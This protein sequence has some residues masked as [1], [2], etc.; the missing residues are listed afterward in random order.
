MYKIAIISGS[1]RNGR[2]THKAVT[3]LA[4]VFGQN[5]QAAKVDVLDVL[6]YNF[7]I[8]TAPFSA[9]NDYPKGAKE[10]SDILAAADA[11]VFASP[12]YNGTMSGVFKNTVDYFYAEYK[13]KPIGIMTVASGGFAGVNASHQLQSLVLSLGGFPMPYKLLVGNIHTSI[14]E[15]NEPTNDRLKKSFQQFSEELLWLTSAIAMKK[16]A[17]VEAV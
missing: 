13:R 7:P 5:K 17:V 1:A 4:K 11:I 16:K 6:A 8:M 15:N 3:Y 10:F 9:E 2:Q 14:D 12:E